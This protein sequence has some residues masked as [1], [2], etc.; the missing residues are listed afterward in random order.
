[1]ILF[2]LFCPESRMKAVDFLKSVER[3]IFT[4]VPDLTVEKL[5]HQ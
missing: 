3:F 2:A 4:S 1:M 5:K